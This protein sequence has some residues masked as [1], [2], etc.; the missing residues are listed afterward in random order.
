MLKYSSI[1][2]D[3]LKITLVV[4]FTYLVDVLLLDIETKVLESTMLTL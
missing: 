1:L 4:I 2:F 3:F